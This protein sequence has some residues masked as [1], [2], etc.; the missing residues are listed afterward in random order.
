MASGGRADNNNNNIAQMQAA[1]KRIHL[2]VE[3]QLLAIERGSLIWSH[4]ICS[5]RSAAS[6]RRPRAPQSQRTRETSPRKVARH[7]SFLSGV[8]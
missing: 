1:P 6:E 4:S 5:S 7:A 2:A 3:Q 8:L